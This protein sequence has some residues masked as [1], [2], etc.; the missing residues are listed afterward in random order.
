MTGKSCDENHYHLTVCSHEWT[1]REPVCATPSFTFPLPPLLPL[2]LVTA[3]ISAVA[4]GAAGRV[5]R[6]NLG[7]LAFHRTSRQNFLALCWLQ[8]ASTASYALARDG[9]GGP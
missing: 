2:L 7:M 4:R 3:A 8:Q 6:S 9:L 5:C 1:N